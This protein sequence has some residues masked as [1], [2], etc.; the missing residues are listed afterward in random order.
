MWCPTSS[1]NSTQD[2][3]RNTDSEM[4]VWCPVTCSFTTPPGDAE[5]AKIQE[6]MFWSEFGVNTYGG[7]ALDSQYIKCRMACMQCKQH[8]PFLHPEQTLHPQQVTQAALWPRVIHPAATTYLPYLP[9]CFAYLVKGGGLVSVCSTKRSISFL[10]C[11]SCAGKMKIRNISIGCST[12]NKQTLT[13]VWR[14]NS[15][16]NSNFIQFYPDIST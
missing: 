14:L 10:N 16:H 6:L 11:T 8:S 1:V 3:V 13:K 4:W 12:D 7:E 15:K 5:A 9:W 2:G